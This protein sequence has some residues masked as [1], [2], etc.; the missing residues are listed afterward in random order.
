MTNFE[1]TFAILA[2]ILLSFIIFYAN[3]FIVASNDADKPKHRFMSVGEL[4][5][6]IAE[7]PDEMP[8]ILFDISTGADSNYFISPDNFEIMDCITHEEYTHTVPGLFLTFENRL[9]DNP[10]P[11]LGGPKKRNKRTILVDPGKDI[12]LVAI[13]WHCGWVELDRVVV[14]SSGTDNLN[15]VLVA[16]T[17]E[18]LGDPDPRVYIEIKD[19]RNYSTFYSYWM[20]W[21]HYGLSLEKFMDRYKNQED[22]LKPEYYFQIEEELNKDQA[23]KEQNGYESN[24]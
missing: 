2:I 16:I 14:S 19:S 5:A 17:F 13:M 24:I 15:G 4:R 11:E 20:P 18:G 9:N 8:F 22:N 6:L 21:G 7:F 3:R 1:I 10:L 12:Y 23:E